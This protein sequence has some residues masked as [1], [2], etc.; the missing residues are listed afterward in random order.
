MIEVIGIENSIKWQVILERCGEY[1]FYYTAEHHRCAISTEQEKPLLLSFAIDEY[2]I[3]LPIILRDIP[4][5][6]MLKDATSVYGYAG[7]LSS[8]ADM[9]MEVLSVFKNE[10]TNWLKANNIVTI[11]SRLHPMY[12]Y[13]DK[14]LPMDTVHAISETVSLDLTLS[15]EETWSAFRSSLRY[16][17]RK[18][19][20]EGF[21]CKWL[22]GE[23]G[24]QRFIEIYE[25]NMR[26]VKAIDYY[27]FPRSYYEG[28]F[29]AKEF[30]C[31]ILAAKRDGEV[32]ACS[33]FIHTKNGVQYHLSATAEKYLKYSPVKLIIEEARDYFKAR[34][35]KWLH[36]GGGVG[37]K[38]DNLMKF[39]TAF[40]DRRHQFKIWKY[41]VNTKH[42]SQLVSKLI[43]PIQEPNTFF[44]LYRKP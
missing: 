22:E 7:P 12:P 43:G 40:S 4:G 32:A 24:L 31:K 21:H 29:Y 34:G 35:A 13:Q 39:K 14:F 9:P 25:E 41:I 38:E 11:F 1:D 23:M 30:E 28:I 19:R 33:M 26:R 3:A 5:E 17:I 37:G 2:Y 44:P 10:L 27:Y 18:L 20:K 16:D 42:Y 36:L 6:L 15:E 8:H